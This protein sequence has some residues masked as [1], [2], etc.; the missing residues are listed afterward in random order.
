MKNKDNKVY[1]SIY[2]RRRKDRDTVSYVAEINFQG[3]R[4]RP[5]SKDKRALTEWMNEVCNTLNEILSEYQIELE[6]KT[7]EL[8]HRLYDDMINRITPVLENAK[9]YDMRYEKTARANGIAITD[10]F[11]TYLIGDMETG[12]T[13]IG[14]S[15][16][17]Y[18]RMQVMCNPALYL[19]AYCDKDI[20]TMLHELYAKQRV[21]GE[22]FNLT[23]DD[24]ADIILQYG[25]TEM[26]GGVVFI[27]GGT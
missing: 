25:F 23:E 17:I 9:A 6:I 26:G 13:K 3:Q 2:E 24:R 27:D 8:K 19:I 18:K 11:Q 7:K 12:L 21:K 14:K 22:W 16:D 5:N 10:Y 20:E 15:H 4:I 1:G